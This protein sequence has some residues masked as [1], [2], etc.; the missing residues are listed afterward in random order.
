MRTKL[1]AAFFAC[2]LLV[3]FH[4]CVFAPVNAAAAPTYESEIYIADNPDL[5]PIEYYDSEAKT[6]KGVLPNLY[7]KISESTGIKFSYI[8]AGVKNEQQQLAEN[9]QVDIV[10]AHFKGEVTGVV[11]PILLL[12]FLKDVENIDVMIGFTDIADKSTAALVKEQLAAVPDSELLVLSLQA[13]S[14]RQNTHPVW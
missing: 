14:G 10:S 11:D 7:A 13:S 1:T 12:S 5:Y 8:R 4:L 3:C 2:L 9:K 6:Y